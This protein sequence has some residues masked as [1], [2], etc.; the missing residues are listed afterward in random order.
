MVLARLDSRIGNEA[1]RAPRLQRL[2]AIA[3]G[4]RLEERALRAFGFGAQLQALVELGHQ[5]VP[6]AHAHQ[7]E[8]DQRAAGDEVALLP[9]GAE[10]VRGCR[11]SPWETGAAAVIAP[12]R[13]GG[14]GC[15]RRRGRGGGSAAADA[16]CAKVALG[17]SARPDGRARQH[18][19]KTRRRV[20]Y[21][22]WMFFLSLSE[23]CDEIL[24]GLCPE[25]PILTS[26]EL[27]RACSQNGTVTVMYLPCPGTCT[28]R[29]CGWS[30][31]RRSGSLNAT[32]GCP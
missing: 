18:C 26:L 12:A 11:P 3:Q 13:G 17:S 9:E 21:D 19:R 28:R 2:R 15:G 27:T 25:G 23:V 8:D 20:G 32:R 4:L 5:D 30:C 1:E 31:G 16:A 29:R 10:A 14:V 24:A 22:A 6:A 7:D